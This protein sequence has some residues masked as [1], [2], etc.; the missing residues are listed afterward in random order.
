MRIKWD[1][2]IKTRL[3]NMVRIALYK[4]K[5]LICLKRKRMSVGKNILKKMK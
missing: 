2:N 5:M 3:K 1:K 4:Y